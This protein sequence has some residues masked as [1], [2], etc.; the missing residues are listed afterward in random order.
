[1]SKCRSKSLISCDFYCCH[2]LFAYTC[3]LICFKTGSMQ[4][5]VIVL[6]LSPFLPPT[7]PLS[8]IPPLPLHYFLYLSPFI[9]SLSSPLSLPLST[10]LY[11][12]LMFISVVILFSFL[13]KINIHRSHKRTI[14]AKRVRQWLPAVTVP[15]SSPTQ[16]TVLFS[17]FDHTINHQLE[18][19]PYKLRVLVK[20]CIPTLASLAFM[21][22]ALF[23]HQPLLELFWPTVLFPKPPKINDVISCFLIPAGLVYA[24]A[25]GFAFQEASAQQIFYR[26]WIASYSTVIKQILLILRRLNGVEQHYKLTIIRQIK[27]GLISCCQQ[28]MKMENHDKGTG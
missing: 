17:A 23:L 26:K 13:K 16:E 25:F 15:D 20:M 18:I 9:P 1:M 7:L 11:I 14:H 8:I 4:D 28:M 5:D 21:P 12:V 24:I 6:C 27:C 10:L 2:L 19:Y 22:V 3:S